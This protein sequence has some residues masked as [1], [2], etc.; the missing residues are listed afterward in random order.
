MNVYDQ[1]HSLKNA[2]MESEE[3]KRYASA[4]ANMESKDEL[5]TMLQDYQARQ[6]SVQGKQLMG[7]DVSQEMVQ[8][9]QD[10][11]QIMMKDP[12]AAEYL[13]CE[14]RFAIMMQDVYKILGEVVSFGQ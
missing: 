3:Y 5:K 10:L 11:Y 4:K 9:M 6:L 14:M 7:E 12:M 8:Q 13:Q 1:A 2:I